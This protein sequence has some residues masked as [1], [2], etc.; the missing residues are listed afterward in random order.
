M[1]LREGLIKIL[2]NF[3]LKNKYKKKNNTII[4][5]ASSATLEALEN[6]FKPLPYL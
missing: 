1:I 5:G 2:K 6:G 4:I 3:K